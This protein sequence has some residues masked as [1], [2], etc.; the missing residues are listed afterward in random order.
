MPGDSYTLTRG[1]SA[2]HL[3]DGNEA[4]ESAARGLLE[5]LGTL[6]A[7]GFPEEGDSLL[8]APGTTFVTV[9]TQ[10]GDTLAT[11]TLGGEEG[12]R[13]VTAEGDDTVYR[14]PAFRVDRLVPSRERLEGG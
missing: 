3:A 7:N 14:I 2:W 8:D 4:D 1:D 12:D 6:R 9:L 13:W 11:L 5:E 10:A